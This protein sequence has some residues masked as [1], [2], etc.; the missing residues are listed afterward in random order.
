MK[1]DIKSTTATQ[2]PSTDNKKKKRK[3]KMPSAIAIIIGVVVFMAILTWIPHGATTDDGVV[4][5]GSLN[6]WQAYLLNQELI[7]TGLAI[8]LDPDNF[9]QV[10]LEGD[11]KEP[12][13][14][15]QSIVEN[16]I[17]NLGLQGSIVSSTTFGNEDITYTFVTQIDLPFT[18]NA[19]EDGTLSRFGLF[20]T[21][22]A[23]IGGYQAA[24][25]IALYLVGIY[26]VVELLIR[27]GTLKSGVSSLV[28]GLNGHELILLP[29]L[30]LLFSLGGTLFGMQEET[31]GLI[32]IIVPVIVLAGFDAPVALMVIVLGTTTGIAASVLD[33]FSVGVMAEGL[34]VTIGTGILERMLLF[35][36]YT[37]IGMG[38]VTW[39]GSR[40]QKDKTKS[41]EK[42]RLEENIKWAENKIGDIEELKPMSGKQKA[43]MLIFAGVFAWM[44]FTLMPWTTWFSDLENNE[45]WIIFSS[46]FYGS[47]LIGEWYFIQLAIL[48]FLAAIVIGK[49]FHYKTSEIARVFWS[50][51]KEMFGVITIIAFSRATSMIMSA[52]GL[53][54]GMVYGLADPE[55][56][57]NMSPILFMIIWFFIFLLMAV[58]IPSTSGLAGITAPIIGG[59]ISGI[60]SS[61]GSAEETIMFTVGILMIYPLAQGVINMFCPTTG[62]VIVQSQQS[63]VTFGRV[64]PWLAAY[65]GVIA[66]VGLICSSGILF[67]EMNM[68]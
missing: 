62:L 68:W 9:G 67:I 66:I 46:I 27:T 11:N 63:N 2:Q 57:E 10:I 17:L 58:F 3:L 34:G 48:F 64:M 60:S 37:S 65:A 20:D 14:D 12:P 45:G 50:S 22:L 29:V 52:S 49:L 30:F 21:I 61:G 39:Y 6:E 32:P 19:F 59:V 18:L 41:L 53:T 42:E 33:P 31:L 35:V 55:S 28:K 26:A 36:V 5:G 1:T 4:L 24:F 43:S 40:V 13:E 44:V 56:F 7:G 47:V 25:S 16:A 54:F 51:L 15:A 8:S 38:F 23:M